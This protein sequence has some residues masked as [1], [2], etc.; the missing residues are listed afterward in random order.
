MTT[1]NLTLPDSLKDFVQEH[2]SSAGYD[3]PSD[4]ILA[5]I[6]ADQRQKAQ[7]NLEQALL[8]GLH[9]GASISVDDQ[10]WNRLHRRAS[11]IN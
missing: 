9:S 7:D 2:F 8:K 10:F 4:Y 1:I 5:L 3:N 11:G 6:R